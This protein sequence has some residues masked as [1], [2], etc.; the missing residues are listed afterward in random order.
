MTSKS[1]PEAAL[2]SKDGIKT[3]QTTRKTRSEIAKLTSKST[4]KR[5]ASKQLSPI[6]SCVHC[7]SLFD[8]V[9]VLCLTYAKT[10]RERNMRSARKGL[11]GLI[12]RGFQEDRQYARGT[13][14]E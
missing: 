6:S 8:P 7:E 11:R 4:C 2:Y 10:P 12:P 1:V 9:A 3:T 13:Y 5:T 14:P